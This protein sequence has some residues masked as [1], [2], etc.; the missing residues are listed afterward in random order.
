MENLNDLIW[1]DEEDGDNN[2]IQP[3]NELMYKKC[4]TAFCGAGN[5]YGCINDRPERS[6]SC[7]QP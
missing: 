7:M 5:F 2:D 3:Q 6:L 4:M 1:T